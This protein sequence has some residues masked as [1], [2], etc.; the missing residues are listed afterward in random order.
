M[1]AAYKNPGGGQDLRPALGSAGLR[2]MSYQ[3]KVLTVS[4]S[5]IRGEREDQSGPAV[6][7]ALQDA[8]F[9]V[10]EQSA[11]PDGVASVAGDITRMASAF[12]GLVV[13]TGGTGFGP[14]T[15][16]PKGQPK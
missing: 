9:E 2:A 3:A 16:R 5:V 14:G 8:G 11:A 15:S 12:T 4:D 13:T 10:I 7:K 6:V 1:A